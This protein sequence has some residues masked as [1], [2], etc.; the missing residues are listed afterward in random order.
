MRTATEVK[1][2]LDSAPN[3]M[4]AYLDPASIGIT[5]EE[6]IEFQRVELEENAAILAAVEADAAE[7]RAWRENGG[8]EA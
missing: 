1:V 8:K 3:Y 7:K 6:F 4:D 2:L 5:D